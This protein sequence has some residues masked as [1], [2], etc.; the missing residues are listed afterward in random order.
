MKF[1]KEIQ[2]HTPTNDFIEGKVGWRSPSNIALVKYWGKRAHQIPENPSISLTLDASYTTT[3]CS[4]QSR[5]PSDGVLIEFLFEGKENKAFAKRIEKWLTS[6]LHDFLFLKKFKLIFESENSFPHS[7]GIASSASAMSAIALCLCEI[8]KQLG[9]VQED[10]YRKA[11]YIA[12]LGSGSACRSIYGHAALWGKTTNGFDEYAIP[13][14]KS[15]DPIFHTFKDAILIVDQSPKSVSSSLG[16]SLMN[17]N[18]FAQPRYKQ[19]NDNLTELESAMAVGDLE[20]MGKI[21]ES[22]ALTLHAMMMLSN[23]ILL[24]PGS[25]AIIERVRA[26]RKEKTWPVYFTIDAGPNIHLLYP[27]SISKKM[28]TFI[29]DELKQYCQ[30]GRIIY[31]Q[32]GAG[33][34]NL[35]L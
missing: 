12:R 22:E 8:E 18:A 25:L 32:V 9:I 16:H 6:L 11:S 3:Y 19:A 23:F 5:Q 2:S 13:M 1:S 27:E 10:F 17:D 35:M 7:T 14:S 15:I 26:K 29:E 31:D 4:Y 21:V 20:K 28:T 24:K 34:I 30:D 33:P